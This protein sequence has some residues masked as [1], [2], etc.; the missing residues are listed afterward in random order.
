M[1][2]TRSRQRLPCPPGAE[3][4]LPGF[5]VSMTVHGGIQ[6]GAKVDQVQSKVEGKQFRVSGEDKPGTCPS[7]RLASFGGMTSRV[8]LRALLTFLFQ[9]RFPRQQPR[10]AASCCRPGPPRLG[11]TSFPS[12]YLPVRRAHW[13]TDSPPIVLQRRRQAEDVHTALNV[14]TY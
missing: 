9:T 10:E 12:T 3:V 2:L 13:C 11:V 5:E 6:S 7:T 4:S 14:R 1:F 8:A